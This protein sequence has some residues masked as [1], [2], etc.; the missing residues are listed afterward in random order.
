MNR[1]AGRQL[2][3]LKDSALTFDT[4]RHAFNRQK[5]MNMDIFCLAQ[6]GMNLTY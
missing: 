2:G 4:L 5:G 6:N 1:I 3:N